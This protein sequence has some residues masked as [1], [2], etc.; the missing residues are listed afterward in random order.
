MKIVHCKYG[1]PMGGAETL[2]VDLMNRQVDKHQVYLVLINNLFNEELASKI[3]S[4]VCIIRLDRNPGSRNPWFILRL[5]WLLFFSIRPDVLHLHS[6]SLPAIILY[7][8]SKLFAT[9]H[10][11]NVP[12]DYHKRYHKVFAISQ[13]VYED[14]VRRVDLPNKTLILAPN[15]IDCSRILAKSSAD[16]NS[17]PKVECSLSIVQV[18]RFEVDKKGQDLLIEAVRYLKQNCAIEIY[19]TFIGDGPGLGAMKKLVDTYGLN[20]YVSFWGTKCREFVY[21]HLRDFDLLVQPSRVEGFGLT[22]AEAMSA[23]VP[24]LVSNIDGPMEIIASGKYGYYFQT[25]DSSDLARKIKYIYDNY[26]TEVIPVAT[27]AKEYV[28]KTYSI[29]AM[30]DKYEHV[31][32]D[33]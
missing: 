7:P 16:D 8:K 2:L 1:F 4:R 22:V 31:Y 33:R 21:E 29:D 13:A 3:D 11:I 23:R 5:N 6:Y 12:I 17:S 27:K 30:V 26:D 32:Y 24:V 9:I 10:A 19:L 20:D 25:E 14:I 18:S 28:A 15:G